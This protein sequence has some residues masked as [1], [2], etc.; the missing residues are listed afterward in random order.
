MGKMKKFIAVHHNPGID[1]NKVQANWRRL[2]QVES[3]QW[4]RTYFDDKDGWR[5]CY[6]LAPDADELKKIFDEMDVSFER[7]VEVE[8]TVPD[9]WGDRWE[10]HLKADAEASNLGD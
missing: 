2:A 4:V 8:E 5:F 3:A 9:M 7:I 1:C 10:A 6:W